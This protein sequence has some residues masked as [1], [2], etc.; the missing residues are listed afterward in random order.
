M[1]ER[2]SACLGLE[3][4]CPA[5][6]GLEYPQEYP[7]VTGPFVLISAWSLQAKDLPSPLVLC[8]I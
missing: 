8:F 3:N 4:G 7:Q 2:A 6:E 1:A 5:S